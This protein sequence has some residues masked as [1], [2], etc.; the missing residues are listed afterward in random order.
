MKPLPTDLEVSRANPAPARRRARTGDMSA[1]VEAEIGSLTRRLAAA[2]EGGEPPRCFS[3]TGYAMSNGWLGPRREQRDRRASRRGCTRW[4]RPSRAKTGRP[5][6][7]DGRGPAKLV[8]C[9]RA[10]AASL[11]LSQGAVSDYL[12]RARAAGVDWPLPEDVD[13]A[14]LE[15]LLFPP[16]SGIPADQRPMPDWGWVQIPAAGGRSAGTRPRRPRF[17]VLLMMALRNNGERCVAIHGDVG[18]S[19]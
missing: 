3:L 17:I 19:P 11:G 16:P 18:L 12:G 8:P 4:D 2:Q 10:I 7:R 14:R 5:P 6:R 1:S 9:R 13:D 15:A